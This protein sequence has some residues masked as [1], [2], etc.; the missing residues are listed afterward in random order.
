MPFCEGSDKFQKLFLPPT[1][2]I[3]SSGETDPSTW[4]VVGLDSGATP[5]V[6]FVN[7]KAG[8]QLGEQIIQNLNQILN[9]LQIF[10]LSKG[11]PEPGLRF[12]E[13]NPHVNWIAV[14]CGGDG[15]AAWIFSTEDKMKMNKVPPLAHCPLGT[16]NDLSRMSGWG[17]G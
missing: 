4:K 14:A 12:I 13:T 15:T 17:P 6:V 5:V 10:N 2:L 11:G 7:P 9:P 8:G 1:C 16:G 3:A